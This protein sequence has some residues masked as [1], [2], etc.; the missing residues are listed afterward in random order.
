MS[1]ASDTAHSDKIQSEMRITLRT[2][3][4][5]EFYGRSKATV[6]N[7]MTLDD[8]CKVFSAY[9]KSTIS[10]RLSELLDEGVI[11]EDPHHNGNYL[12]AP[13]EWR[14]ANKMA[15]E[16]RRYEKWKALGI[17]NNWFNK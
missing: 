6:N 10:G 17:K 2:C 14:E 8:L 12:Y 5:L 4:K 1:Q 11:M 13:S 3:M 15:R 9:E 7:S 16:N